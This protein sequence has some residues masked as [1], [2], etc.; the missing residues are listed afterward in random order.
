MK[1]SPPPANSIDWITSCAASLIDIKYLYIFLSV[2]VIGPPSEI[3]LRN[4][5]TTEPEE[6]NT[7]PNLT[8]E[9][10]VELDD[11]EKFC[12]YYSQSLLDAPI[13]FDG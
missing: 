4:R 5:G 13:I 9:N 8:I 2:N 11:E 10:S 6:P 3:C 12:I 7:F 1:T